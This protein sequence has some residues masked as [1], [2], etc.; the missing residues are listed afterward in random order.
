MANP[1]TGD[2]QAVLQVSLRPVNGLLAT[3]HQNGASSESPLK[4][5]HSVRTRIGDQVGPRP[6][7]GSFGDWVHEYQL[8]RAPGPRRPTRHL[9]S[10]ASPPG[11]ARR[12]RELFSDLAIART[13]DK[14]L[15]PV[16]LP[17]CVPFLD[18]TRALLD[19]LGLTEGNMSHPGHYV[20]ERA[21][22]DK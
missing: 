15:T 19:K 13:G 21:F 2:F 18:D 1:L 6:D 20:I 7:L 11:D 17:D 22:V 14:A 10:A 3:L 12:I 8:A 4:L 9:L 5:L 16:P